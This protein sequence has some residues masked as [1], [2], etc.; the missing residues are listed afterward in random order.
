LGKHNLL[1]HDVLGDRNESL[2]GQPKMD[3]RSNFC[4][5][6]LARQCSVPRGTTFSVLFVQ[7]PVAL[8]LTQT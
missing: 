6:S 1:V 7:G 2:A 5:M 4:R 3:E 8:V